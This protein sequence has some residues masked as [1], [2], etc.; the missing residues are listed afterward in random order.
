MFM[1]RRVLSTLT[2]I[3]VV[4]ILFMPGIGA[5]GVEAKSSSCDSL[6]AFDRNNFPDMPVIDNQYLPLIPGT[7]LVLEGTS[8]QGGGPTG[9]TVIFTVTGLTKKIDGVNTVMVWD[10]DFDGDQLAEAELSFWAQDIDGNVWNLAEYPEEY[11]EN[12][13][14]D[15]APST[16]ISGLDGAIGGLHM[17]AEPKRSAGEYLQG[18]SPSIDFLDCAK[19]YR[20]NQKVCVPVNCYEKVL[21]TAERS[22]LE[23]DSGEQLKYHAPGIGIVQIGAVG[24]PEAETLSLTQL[25]YLDNKE[26]RA[27][28]KEARQLDRHGCRTNDLY[29]QTCPKHD[30]DD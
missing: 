19:V 5:P 28:N 11:D 24:D 8:N 7:Q 10:R 23:P 22:P 12:G 18:S 15:G 2:S 6:I 16:W 27:A 14:F 13:K 30:D 4:F 3:I 17:L 21:V 9:H 1:N 25:N 29:H 26:L 20:K